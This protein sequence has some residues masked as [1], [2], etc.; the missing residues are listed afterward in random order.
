MRLDNCEEAIMFLPLLILLSIL[1]ASRV[2][3]ILA[4]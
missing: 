1:G 4:S 2:L 3:M